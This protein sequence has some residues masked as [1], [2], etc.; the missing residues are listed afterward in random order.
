MSKVI[1]ASM[2]LALATIASAAQCIPPTVPTG[3][4]LFPSYTSGSKNYVDLKPPERVA[5]LMLLSIRKLEQRCNDELDHYCTL[6]ELVKGVQGSKQ[7]FNGPLIALTVNPACD[8]HYRYDVKLMAGG[9]QLTIEPLSTGLG[10]FLDDE[11]EPPGMGI[12]YNPSGI[13]TKHSRKLNG[14]GWGVGP[15]AQGGDF[16]RHT[17]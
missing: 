9:W 5:Y 8:I 1:F 17:G 14:N 10:G 13:A 3:T 2:S 6:P 12:Y 16:E 11:T 15:H 7:A 4:K